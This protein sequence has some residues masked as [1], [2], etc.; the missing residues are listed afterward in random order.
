M[1]D[2]LQESVR[3]P[4]RSPV[5]RYRDNPYPEWLVLGVGT[6]SA[7]LAMSLGSRLD[8]LA[9]VFAVLFAVAVWLG[10]S[11]RFVATLTV[12]E[13]RAERVGDH[14]AMLRTGSIRLADVRSMRER[15][16]DRV[17]EVHGSSGKM[18]EI[19]MSVRNYELLNNTLTKMTAWYRR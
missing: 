9:I 4:G 14:W 12:Q 8:P 16:G 19:P 15:L 10:T 1:H 17:L 3:R 2:E 13:I 5:S 7:V 11:K 6:L 18:I